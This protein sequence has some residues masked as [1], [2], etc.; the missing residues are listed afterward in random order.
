[1]QGN[2]LWT[3]RARATATPFSLSRSSFSRPLPFSDAAPPLSLLLHRFSLLLFTCPLYNAVVFREPFAA[4]TRRSNHQDRNSNHTD[5]GVSLSSRSY[6]NV[7]RTL[8]SKE[9][10]KAPTAERSCSGLKAPS[11][12]LARIFN[13]VPMALMSLPRPHT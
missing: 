1:M 12:L 10:P 8:T 6:F 11:W 9:S 2:L 7:D 5:D 4:H 13:S 3:S